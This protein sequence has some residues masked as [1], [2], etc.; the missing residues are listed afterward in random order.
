[1]KT[2]KEFLDSVYRKYNVAKIKKSRERR[3]FASV[4]IVLV[5]CIAAS[6]MF[7]FRKEKMP[8]AIVSEDFSEFFD[9]SEQFCSSEESFSSEFVSSVVSED[10]SESENSS[11]TSK[12]FLENERVVYSEKFFFGASSDFSV[13]NEEAEVGVCYGNMDYFFEQEEFDGVYYFVGIKA[14]MNSTEENIEFVKENGVEAFRKKSILELKD[15][16]ESNGFFVQYME[17]FDLFISYVRKED[18]EKLATEKA[19]L[20]VYHLPHNFKDAADGLFE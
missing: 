11:V 12:D 17:E 2:E 9:E 8:E 20:L 10:Y 1:M 5:V 3:A 7:L 13:Q 14:I 16:F 18:I 4:A 15:H 6:L 19:S